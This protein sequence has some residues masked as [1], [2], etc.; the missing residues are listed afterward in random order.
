MRGTAV[1]PMENG[2]LQKR[3]AQGHCLS[4]R[5]PG[6]GKGEYPVVIYTPNIVGY[7]PPKGFKIVKIEKLAD[8]SYEVT[9]EPDPL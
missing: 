6:A 9:L 1:S 7:V 4:F 2:T 3:K 5:Y 8:G